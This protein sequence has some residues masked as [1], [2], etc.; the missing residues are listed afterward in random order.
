VEASAV[1]LDRGRY[2]A[3]ALR[4]EDADGRWRVTALEIG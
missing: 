2:R 1:V 3:I 4:L